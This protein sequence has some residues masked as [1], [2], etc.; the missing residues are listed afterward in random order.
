MPNI[1]IIDDNAEQSETLARILNHYLKKFGSN[2]NVLTKFP[3]KEKDLDL[4]FEYIEDNDV[5]L[6]ILDERLNDKEVP[7]GGTIEYKGNQLVGSLRTRLKDFPIF[8][9]TAHADDDELLAR[10]SD[11]EGIFN[12]DE[13]TVKEE[14]ANLNVPRLI[15]AAQ[16]FLESNNKELS[17]FN[18]I[19]TAIS[20]GDDNPKLIE[21]LQALQIKLELPFSGFDDRNSWLNEYED[22]IKLLEN[23][24]KQIKNKLPK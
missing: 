13:I 16:R 8:M 5:C 20:S 21:K 22:Q 7:E 1:A 19:T 2:L 9:V 6:L 10:E 11:F 14:S 23:L 15:R 12:R 3:Y 17:E 24:N 4:Y 18:Q